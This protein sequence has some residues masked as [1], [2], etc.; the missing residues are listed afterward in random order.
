MANRVAEWQENVLCHLR[1]IKAEY[2]IWTNCAAVIDLSIGTS[3]LLVLFQV[4]I[5]FPGVL[6]RL[7]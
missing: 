2:I 6:H 3:I 1:F 7:N 4:L 5:S